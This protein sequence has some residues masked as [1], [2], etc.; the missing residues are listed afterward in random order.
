MGS[1]LCRLRGARCEVPAAPSPPAPSHPPGT[2]APRT[3]RITSYAYIDLH[4]GLASDIVRRTTEYVLY[5]EWLR[6]RPCDATATTRRQRS[7][8]GANSC[9]TGIGETANCRTGEFNFTT[10][11]IHHPTNSRE[12]GKMREG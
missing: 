8:L 10:S 12:L 4:P 9:P 5:P 2:F 3:I 6:D 11:P 7:R 1:A